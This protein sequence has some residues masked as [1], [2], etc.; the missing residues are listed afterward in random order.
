MKLMILVGNTARL[1]SSSPLQAGSRPF[2][3]FSL[4]E[5]KR[6]KGHWQDSC[7]P[8]WRRKEAELNQYP[9]FKRK[10]GLM[11]LESWMC[12]FCIRKRKEGWKGC[13]CCLCMGG[14]VVRV[15]VDLSFEL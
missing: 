14:L 6:L 4:S 8:N 9:H 5:L 3:L 10:L 1:C 11:G 2:P 12:I 15:S 7:L 13:L